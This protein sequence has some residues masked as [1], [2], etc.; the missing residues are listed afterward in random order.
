MSLKSQSP[1]CDRLKCRDAQVFVVEGWL[2]SR[3]G[4]AARCHL[5]IPF[6]VHRVED[7]GAKAMPSHRAR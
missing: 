5:R 1:I 4:I 7:G 6:G 2:G 3:Y